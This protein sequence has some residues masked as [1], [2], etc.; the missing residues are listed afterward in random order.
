MISRSIKLYKSLYTRDIYIK[1]NIEILCIYEYIILLLLRYY[2]RLYS[3][4]VWWIGMEYII[5]FRIQYEWSEIRMNIDIRRAVQ[6]RYCS[7]KR[8][9]VILDDIYKFAS[10][11][12]WYF[13]LKS[14]PTICFILFNLSMDY[15]QD[16]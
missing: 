10:Y 3:V 5:F 15:W 6:N 11:L 14:R 8:Q 13:Y 7:S 2:L 1:E 9:Y 12:K 4:I 16:G